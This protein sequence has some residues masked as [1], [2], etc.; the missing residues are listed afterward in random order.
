MLVTDDAGWNI[1]H[2]TSSFPGQCSWTSVSGD[3]ESSTPGILHVVNTFY[4]PKDRGTMLQAEGRG[5]ETRRGECI[6]SVYLIVPA[7]L[8]PGAYSAPH[9]NEFQ[10]Q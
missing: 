10:R 3:R 7:A 2:A 5:F 9:K 1:R 6:F 8:G 4:L